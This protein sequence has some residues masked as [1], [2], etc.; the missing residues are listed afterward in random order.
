MPRADRRRRIWGAGLALFGALTVCLVFPVIA[1]A[2]PSPS[3]T[4]T[5]AANNGQACDSSTEF[6][7]DFDP[8]TCASDAAGAVATWVGDQ[9]IQDVASWITSAAASGSANLLG[10][11]SDE[12]TR[13]QLNAPWFDSVYYGPAA[14]AGTPVQKGSKMPGAVVIAAWLMV[15]IV[16]ASVLVSVIRGDPGGIARLLLVRLPV[17]ILLTYLATWLVALLLELTDLAS[18]WVLNGGVSGLQQWSS[19]IQ[20]QGIGS[21]FLSVVACL[22]LIVATLLGYLEL[23][24]RD[25]V[26]YIVVA[27]V[28]LIAAASLWPGAHNALKRAAETIFVLCVSKFVLVFVLVLGAAA[29]TSADMNS[30]SPLLTGTLIFLIAALAPAAIFRLIPILEASAVAGLA[31]GAS[32][33]GKSAAK[34]GHGA[35]GAGVGKVSGATARFGERLQQG[36]GQPALAGAGAGASGMSGSSGELQLAGRGG[37]QRGPDGPPDGGGDRG[38]GSAGPSV[39]GSG[40][41]GGG[42]GPLAGG[43][44]SSGPPPAAS[45]PAGGPQLTVVSPGGPEGGDT[46]SPEG[47]R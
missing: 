14:P 32:R 35:L 3:P 10:E 47:R 29:L 33:F 8:L 7:I 21:D 1:G 26:L 30:F 42:S 19:Q 27:F 12:A 31:G 44:G 43:G 20:S 38:P 45:E 5:P 28:P 13:P 34:T 11:L 46:S 18:G 41:G 24:A 36:G 37:G 17:A 9:A 22:A 6:T 16:I 23:M 2:A 25:A 15:P 4:P 39:A 40:G